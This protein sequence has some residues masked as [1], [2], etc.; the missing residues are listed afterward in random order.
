MAIKTNLKNH[1]F[2]SCPLF[3]QRL[4]YCYRRGGGQIMRPSLSSPLSSPSSSSLPSSVG[5]LTDP[6][7]Q[8]HASRLYRIWS[9]NAGVNGIMTNYGYSSQPRVTLGGRQWCCCSRYPRWQ[10]DLEMGLG[11]RTGSTHPLSEVYHRCCRTLSGFLTNNMNFC[12]LFCFPVLI[13]SIR[14]LFLFRFST[15]FFSIFIF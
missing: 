10:T 2:C 5:Y 9:S 6:G 15:C 14:Y 13:P 12:R 1:F 4:K 7:G 3:K 11:P 8:K